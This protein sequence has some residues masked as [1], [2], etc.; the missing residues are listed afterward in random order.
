VSADLTGRPGLRFAVGIGEAPVGLQGTVSLWTSARDL[1]AFAYGGAAHQAVVARTGPARWYSEEL[2]A[3]FA[4]EA[5]HGSV[6]GRDP[7]A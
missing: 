5:A 2:F 1:R 4:V 7:L 3:R 6:D